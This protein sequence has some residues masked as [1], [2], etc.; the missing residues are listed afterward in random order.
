[1]IPESST[2]QDVAIYK[3]VRFP[4]RWERH[5]TLLAGV[6]LSD[7]TI[8]RDNGM[9]Y[10]FAAWRDGAAGY[11]DALAIYYAESLFG[12]W[13]PHVSNPVLIDRA[14]ARPAGNI[15][16]INHRLWRPVQ[17]CARGYGAALGL[18]E[19]V[20]LSPTTFKQIV[21]HSLAPGPA[22]PGRKLHT[23]NRCGRL[24]VIDGSRVQPKT[25]ILTGRF[26]AAVSS[27][28][29]SPYTAC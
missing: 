2:H 21:R 26:P 20:D 11:S 10:L 13:R 19:I 4:D 9:N 24:E 18:A 23:L 12:P 6:E 15:V 28:R 16:T 8:T 14:S 7:V 5:A 17:N 27:P 25:R 22:W 3:C 29:T 1:M